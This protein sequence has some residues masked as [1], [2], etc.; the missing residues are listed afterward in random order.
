MKKIFTTLF[1][2]SLMLVANAGLNITVNT[3][4]LDGEEIITYITKDTTIVVNEF[5]EDMFSG[6]VVMGIKG[7]LYS[8][9]SKTIKVTIERSTTGIKD[10]FCSGACV[11]GNKEVKQE[12][13]VE[14]THEGNTWFTHYYPQ[15]I[16]KETISYSFNDAVN[17]VIKLT[18]VYN[19]SGTAVED[20]LV[21]PTNNTIYNLLGQR[22]PSKNLNEL[23]E[24]IYII[25]G[26]KYIK[27]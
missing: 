9:E 8:L 23:P 13:T 7:N 26:K 20:V 25:N 11:A 15:T 3:E 5:E 12:I 16:G 1:M 14:A 24:G 4:N 21:H 19:Y 22:M 27:Q 2:A 18:V 17:P 6:D 10:E